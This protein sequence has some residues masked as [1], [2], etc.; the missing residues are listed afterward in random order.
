[1]SKLC[2]IDARLGL[3]DVKLAA[4]AAASSLQHCDKILLVLRVHKTNFYGQGPSQFSMKVHSIIQVT[5][6]SYSLL[7]LLTLTYNNSLLVLV[8]HFWLLGGII[9]LYY[10]R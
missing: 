7:Y 3:D 1:M 9:I 4:A 5:Y 10:I 6:D 8:Y 2:G